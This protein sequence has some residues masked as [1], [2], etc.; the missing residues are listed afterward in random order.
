M[1]LFSEYPLS[2]TI[3]LPMVNAAR[4]IP[5][6]SPMASPN[7]STSSTPSTIPIMKMHPMNAITAAKTFLMVILS[8]NKK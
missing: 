8:P 5:D 7:M 3:L 1:A 2:P 6:N 4:V